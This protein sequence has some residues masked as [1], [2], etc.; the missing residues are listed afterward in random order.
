ML[1]V[2][3]CLCIL[4]RTLPVLLS[5]CCF[6]TPLPLSEK[7]SARS[8]L[9]PLCSR[10]YRSCDHLHKKRK[11]ERLGHSLYT[12]PGKS[13]AILF[14]HIDEVHLRPT[15]RTSSSQAK[16]FYLFRFFIHISARQG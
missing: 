5:S 9:S 15:L 12:C 14:Q 16:N 7:D 11:E 8:S 6:H 1:T 2:Y 4:H 13:Y 3:F 10:N